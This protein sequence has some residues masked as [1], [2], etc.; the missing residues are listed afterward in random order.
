M[1]RLISPISSA[2]CG[3]VKTLV[4]S[5]SKLSQVVP[6]ELINESGEFNLSAERYRREI[7]SD[8]AYPLISLGDI[9]KLVRGVTYKKGDEVQDGGHQVLRA[10]NIDRETSTLDLTE[11]K[12][13]SKQLDLSQEK[14]LR[15]HDIFICLASGSKSH[16]GKVAFI[17]QDTHYYFGGFMGAI[18]SDSARCL[19]SLC[20]SSTS[21]SAIQ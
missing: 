19:S 7:S 20:V 4:D 2:A 5:Q 1:C 14:L 21:P 15:L 6:K 3:Q 8:Y 10:N 13:V 17:S 18:R 16:V 9:C 12:Q 11:V